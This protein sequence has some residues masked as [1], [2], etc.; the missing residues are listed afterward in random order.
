MPRTAKFPI[1]ADTSFLFSLFLPDTNTAGA[2][3]F[4]KTHPTPL[5]FTAWQRCELRNAIRLSV[6]RGN[7][8]NQTATAALQRIDIDVAQGDLADTPLVWPVVLDK[9]EA[10]SA[11][12]AMQLG[13]RAL[14]LLHVAAAI[15][16]G[17]GR[18][19]TCDSRQLAL[20]RAAGLRAGKI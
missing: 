16:V 4:L 9:A 13:V 7:H 1:Y 10:L 11:R 8:D 2:I 18:F 15:S 14:D 12:H 3:R 20:A 19:L 6:F 17:A 5:V